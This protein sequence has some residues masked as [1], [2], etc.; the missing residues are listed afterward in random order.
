MTFRAWCYT[1]GIGWAIFL[2]MVM[3]M[4]TVR[5]GPKKDTMT[6]QQLTHTHGGT[7]ELPPGPMRPEG[8]DDI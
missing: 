6:L 1:I 7:V 2:V 8:P 4:W 3:L 5:I